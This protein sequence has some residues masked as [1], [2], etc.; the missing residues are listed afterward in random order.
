MRQKVL[1]TGAMIHDP[2]VLLFDEPLSGLDAHAS[3]TVKEIVREMA[4]RGKTVLYSSHMLDT[5]ERLC[6]RVI[7]LNQG[8]VVI[9]GQPME[10]MKE[11]K[12]DSLEQAFRKLTGGE[13][14]THKASEFADAVRH[15]S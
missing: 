13:D 4:S 10:I 12:A 8:Q 11:A 15:K 2:E 6:N 5:V 14:S 3:Q 9:D 1:I 7:I